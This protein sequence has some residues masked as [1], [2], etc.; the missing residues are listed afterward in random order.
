SSHARDLGRALHARE[1]ALLRLDAG[2]EPAELEAFLRLLGTEGVRDERPPLSEELA[3]KGLTHVHVHAVDFS[4]VRLTD[5]VEAP[6]GPTPAAAT[7]WEALLRE[8]MAGGA[9]SARGR[10]L[11]ESGEA[12]TGKGV[13]ELIGEVLGAG[14]DTA[15]PAAAAGTEGH[16]AGNGPTLPAGA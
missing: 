10:R 11:V 12:A 3:A 13:A 6:P 1:V 16:E 8:V 15:D 14:G 2:I 5:D 7:L 4:Q 9:L